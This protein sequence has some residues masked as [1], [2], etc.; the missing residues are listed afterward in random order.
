M[1]HLSH[2]ISLR[3]IGVISAF[4]M[5]LGLLSIAE[6]FGPFGDE[7]LVNTYTTNTQSSSAIAVDNSGNYVIVW[8][9]NGQDGSSSGIYGQRYNAAGNRLGNEFRVNTTTTN[10]QGSPDIWLNDNGGFVVV[11][12]SDGQD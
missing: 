10:F 11:W 4:C 3:R 9:S 5:L 7:S 8:Q 12:V 1:S 2:L 6:A